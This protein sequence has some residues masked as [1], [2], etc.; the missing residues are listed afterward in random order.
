MESIIAFLLSVMT[1]FYGIFG[2]CDMTN[3]YQFRVDASAPGEE[4]GNLTKCI[5]LW[6]MGTAYYA[7]QRNEKYDIYEFVEYVQL[8]QCTGGALSRDLFKDPSDRNVPDDYDFSRLVKNCAGI[9]SLGAKPHLKL[10]GVPLKY[11]TDPEA[12]VFS[13]NANPPDDYDVYYAY[14]RACAQALVDEGIAEG[15]EMQYALGTDDQTAPA[16]SAFSPSIPPLRLRLS[17]NVGSAYK[18]IFIAEL[19]PVSQGVTLAPVAIK[20]T[21]SNSSGFHASQSKVMKPPIEV[22]TIMSILLIPKCFRSRSKAFTVSWT[23]TLGKSK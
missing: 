10:G 11:T 9:L 17:L 19:N 16:A 3:R 13:E 22:A 21:L 14:I 7:P 12:C 15:G 5:N 6:D 1:F 8:M 20:N 2:W 23:V 18:A 4:I